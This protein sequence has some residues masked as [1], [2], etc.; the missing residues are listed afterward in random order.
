MENWLKAKKGDQKAKIKR[1]KKK[2]TTPIIDNASIKTAQILESDHSFVEVPEVD[3]LEIKDTP[4]K[5]TKKYTPVEFP[6]NNKDEQWKIIIQPVHSELPDSDWFQF[7]FESDKGEWPQIITIKVNLAHQH[8]INIFRLGEPDEIYSDVS[9]EIYRL[10][11]YL[12]IAERK[13]KFSSKNK[14]ESPGTYRR[15]INQTINKIV[16]KRE[17]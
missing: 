14:G 5:E 1:E 16:N 7:R 3:D 17:N 4:I 10:L 9:T 12:A 8:S 11:A 15:F 2:N 13:L 6:I